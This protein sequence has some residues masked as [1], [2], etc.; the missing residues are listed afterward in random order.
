MRRSIF[1]RNTIYRSV[2]I[3][4]NI[5][6][7]RSRHIKKMEFRSRCCFVCVTKK[8]T[9]KLSEGM[10]CLFIYFFKREKKCICGAFQQDAAVPKKNLYFFSLRGTFVG[11]GGLVDFS[12][13]SAFLHKVD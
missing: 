7:L 6:V 12:A 8:R 3:E 11:G 10:R 4:V 2:I 5:E 9:D 13:F 1:H